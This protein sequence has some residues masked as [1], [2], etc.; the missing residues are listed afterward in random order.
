MQLWSDLALY[1]SI[2]AFAGG[3]I[4]FPL[5]PSFLL[6]VTSPSP[7]LSLSV[8]LSF[9]LFPSLPLILPP[10]SSPPLYLSQSLCIS[11]SISVVSRSHSD[12]MKF[13]CET[14]LHDAQIFW[15]YVCARVPRRLYAGELATW[16]MVHHLASLALTK[17][18]NVCELV[19]VIY[20]HFGAMSRFLCM[21]Y[22]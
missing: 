14:F 11:V 3:A 8:P 7:P 20:V 6:R 4:S 19:N 18:W 22:F 5:S 2:G 21:P 13:V 16:A 1:L 15:K 10:P 12:F 9:C 17:F